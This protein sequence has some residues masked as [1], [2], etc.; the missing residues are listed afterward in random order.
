MATRTENKE[1]K[2][3]KKG[4][5]GGRG[6]ERLWEKKGEGKDSREG[7][8]GVMFGEVENRNRTEEKANLKQRGIRGGDQKAWD[9]FMAKGGKLGEKEKKSRQE[10]CLLRIFRREAREKGHKKNPDGRIT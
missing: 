8:R 5:V 1:S 6:G 3:G 9:R 4:G 7:Q 10:G 2:T